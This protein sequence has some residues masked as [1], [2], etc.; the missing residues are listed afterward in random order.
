MRAVVQEHNVYRWAGNLIGELADIRLEGRFERQDRR[1]TRRR[2]PTTTAA[3]GAGAR[4][5]EDNGGTQWRPG[6][7]KTEPS[8][9]H[10]RAQ[11]RLRN[12]RTSIESTLNWSPPAVP[13]T[14]AITGRSV[15]WD[16]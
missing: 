7:K 13:S 10:P 1:T 16:P 6:R 14:V 11:G 12:Q 15:R 3:R 8:W 9:K 4:A 2:E 5:K